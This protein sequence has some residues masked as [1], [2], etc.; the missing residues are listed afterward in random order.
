MA[1]TR[2]LFVPKKQKSAKCEICK[3]CE[4][5]FA[6]E[7]NELG[8]YALAGACCESDA[9]KW[10]RIEIQKDIISLD[11]YWKLEDYFT[12]TD[13][14]YKEKEETDYQVYWMGEM[15]RPK[16]KVCS[17][18][19]NCGNVGTCEK[20][21]EEEKLYNHIRVTGKVTE[22]TQQE[23]IKNC[24]QLIEVSRGHEDFWRKALES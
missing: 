2:Y 17:K 22:I 4:K 14:I 23:F 1:K 19:Q 3:N 20:I 9:G 12:Q 7:H 18:C 8:F 13:F 16:S 5:L 10:Y 11:E 24:P 6:C 15:F 21:G